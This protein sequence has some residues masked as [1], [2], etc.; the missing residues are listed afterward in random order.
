MKRILTSPFVAC[1]VLQMTATR[2][3]RMRCRQM[4][5]ET[6]Y[7]DQALFENCMEWPDF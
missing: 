7:A 6:M 5:K 2:H 3:W 1:N 4:T